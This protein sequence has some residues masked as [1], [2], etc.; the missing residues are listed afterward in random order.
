MK[1]NLNKIISQNSN[2][3]RRKV[4][5]LLKEGKIKLNNKIAN[6][7]DKFSYG[8]K[9]EVLG[10][11]LEVRENK[12][13][14][15]IKLNKPVGYVC[16][17]KNFKEEKNIFSL[18]KR[19]EKLFSIG[20]LDKNSRG[21]IILTND[22]DLAYELSHP[23]FE[24]K[25]VYIVKTKEENKDKKIAEKFIKG[26]DIKQKTLAKARDFKELSKNKFKITLSE[27]KKRQI[28]EM[29]REL[30]LQV[31]D[32]KRTSFSQVE[33]GDLKEGEYKEL[34]SEEIEKLKL[35]AVLNNINKEKTKNK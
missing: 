18:V 12:K 21:I 19:K 13:C 10:K 8:D 33:L 34:S 25:K 30:D 31:S 4:E 20:R 29:F 16:S 6:P 3:P 35:F 28:R 32:L 27:G 11:E 14:L 23:K 17:N 15:Y 1:E 2:Y 24:H 5:A 7:G 9:V 22:G 26:I